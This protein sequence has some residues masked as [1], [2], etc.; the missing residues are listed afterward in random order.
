MGRLIPAGTGMEFYRN[1]QIAPDSTMQETRTEEVDDTQSYIDAMVAATTNRGI[2]EI[3]VEEVEFDEFDDH[4]LDE[5][6][7]TD[8]DADAEQPLNEEEF[9]MD[10]D[11]G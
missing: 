1:V 10:E 8:E 11:L 7:G 9:S 2:P 5:E 3:E 6:V 4:G